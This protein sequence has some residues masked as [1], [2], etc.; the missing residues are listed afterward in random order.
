MVRW[1]IFPKPAGLLRDDYLLSLWLDSPNI[2]GTVHSD[3]FSV[4]WNGGVI[5]DQFEHRQIGWNQF[6]IHRHGPT[7]SSTVLQLGFRDDPYYFGLDDINVWPIPKSILPFRSQNGH[8]RRGVRLEFAGPALP[9]RF[10][11]S[12]NLFK[13]NWIILKHQYRDRIHSDVHQF[14]WHGP[15]AILPHPP[16]ALKFHRP[17]ARR[18]GCSSM[19]A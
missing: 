17:F 19:S 15:A 11:Y 6:A 3:E 8:Q 7:G 9:I 12:T 4:S 2:S 18:G 10:S 16:I 1:V 14:L 13:T 5:F